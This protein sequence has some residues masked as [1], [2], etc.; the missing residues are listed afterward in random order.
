MESNSP[1]SL[2][3][4][5]SFHNEREVLPELISRLQA[6][7]IG[8]IENYELLFVDDCSNDGSAEFLSVAM[9]VNPQIRVLKTS[10]RF[11]GEGCIYSGIRHARGDAIVVM[12]ADLQD[13]PELLPEMIKQWRQGYEVVYTV[14]TKRKGESKLKL[15]IT[16]IGY[17]VLKHIAEIDMPINAGNF[18]LISRRV[19]QQLTVLNESTPYFRGLVHWAGFRQKRIYYSRD[20][21]H[22]GETH[23][24]MMSYMAIS[25]FLTGVFS[26][27]FKPLYIAFF[28]CLACSIIMLLIGLGDI[29]WSF[30]SEANLNLAP[31]MLGAIAIGL[32][33]VSAAIAIIMIYFVQIF[34]MIKRRPSAL[35]EHDYHCYDDEITIA[36][37]STEQTQ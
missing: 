7:L 29:L 14:R 18:K 6:S 35:I 25:E 32:G 21:R 16:A 20:A 24:S 1:V 33:V 2:S 36:R 4:I 13:P 19:A 26:F 12:D 10:R 8:V 22:A 30:F 37:Q 15:L 11:G 28:S 5:L 3:V 34:P 27:S 9:K 31:L 17:R 23:V